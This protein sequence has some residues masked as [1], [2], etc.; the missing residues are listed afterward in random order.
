MIIYIRGHFAYS[1]A[2]VLVNPTNLKGH[3]GNVYA[4][5]IKAVYPPLA[6][7]MMALARKGELKDG[8]V[9]LARL[10]RH[11]ILSMPIQAQAQSKIDPG[12]IEAGLSKFCKIYD[13]LLMTSISF[14]AFGYGSD[15]W[16][17]IQSLMESYLEALPIRV[18][19]HLPDE[20]RRS[21]RERRAFMRQ[22]AVHVSFE[23]FWEAVKEAFRKSRRLRT[24]T[25]EKIGFQVE[26]PQS[27]RYPDRVHLRL[28]IPDEDEPLY[29]SESTLKDLWVY[30]SE[31]GF[32]VPSQLP[33][34]LEVYGIYII[35]VLAELGF[36]QVTEMALHKGVFQNGLLFQP[37]RSRQLDAQQTKL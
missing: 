35:A 7:T 23:E 6:K 27:K 20:G 26:I 5:D 4:A 12:L 28:R 1:S 10:D 22:Y 13:Q 34:G 25:E 33:S 14:P 2:K 18:F 30:A 37:M 24:Y 9:H 11:W 36:F 8:K 29:L 3:M 32:V 21:S 15:G 16:P 31:T 17:E 19:I